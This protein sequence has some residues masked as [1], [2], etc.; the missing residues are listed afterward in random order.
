VIQLK[1]KSA[2]SIVF[3][4]NLQVEIF[5]DFIQSVLDNVNLITDTKT[6]FETVEITK[7]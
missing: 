5:A 7:G 1:D 3:K 6:I 4:D 2:H